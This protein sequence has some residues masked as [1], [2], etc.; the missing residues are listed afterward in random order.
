MKAWLGA[1]GLVFLAGCAAVGL[2]EKLNPLPSSDRV[3]LKKN[4]G[5]VLPVEELK[6]A[7]TLDRLGTFVN[8]LPRR[9]SV[10]WYGPPV[11]KVYFTFYRAG[12][13]VG[14]FYVGPN[15]FGRDGGNFWSQSASKKQM[16]ELS[17][18]VGFDLWS[19]V[20]EK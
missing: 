15:F 13:S 2:G 17:E 8:A 20:H 6:D 18:I 14:N 5:R 1:L 11:G 7:A 4:Y 3:A 9:W 12:K 16:D 19:Y 10:P